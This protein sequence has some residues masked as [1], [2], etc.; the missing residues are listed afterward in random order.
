MPSSK[1][2]LD[3]V[4]VCKGAAIIGVLILHIGNRRYGDETLSLFHE[5]QKWAAWSVYAFLFL[6]GYLHGQSSREESPWAFLA[7]RAQRLLWPACWLSV[8]YSVLYHFARKVLPMDFTAD[9]FAPT[10]AGKLSDSLL[11]VVSLGI[12]GQRAWL[13]LYFFPLLFWISAVFILLTCVFS[14]LNRLKILCGVLLAVV[15]GMAFYEPLPTS[16]LSW[17]M[18]VVG[19]F[20]YTLAFLLG[21]TSS[22]VRQWRILATGSFVAAMIFSFS[23]GHASLLI[24]II[25]LLLFLVLKKIAAVR[26]LEPLRMAGRASASIFAFHLPFVLLPLQWLF[27]RLHAPILINVVLS[28]ALTIAVC[29]GIHHVL[30]KTPAL[31]W[32]RI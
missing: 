9:P 19:L 29:T 21:K 30:Q 11:Y 7:R 22:F 32:W 27:F 26:W 15:V 2:R 31:R 10:L 4:D 20:Q 3:I 6:A 1:R 5:I 17:Q 16:V 13:Q 18:I 12:F 25:P 14:S 23:L 24:L 8:L 28:I